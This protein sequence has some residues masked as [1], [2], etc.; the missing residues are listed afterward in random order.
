MIH[1]DTS[2]LIR[3]LVRGSVEDTWLRRW[4][5]A[6]DALGMSAI[7]WT[8][9]LCGPVGA[10]DIAIATRL[11]TE[12]P[13]FT[14]D[15][16]ALA[17]EL[18]NTSGRRRGSLADCMIAATALRAEAPLATSNREDFTRLVAHGL[19]LLPTAPARRR[20]RPAK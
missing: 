9:F 6:G 2:F 14:D 16:T 8:E 12:R 11:V 17:A 5:G 13:A 19:V 15:D 4:L 18:F 10:N 1:V 3:G 20:A 7:A